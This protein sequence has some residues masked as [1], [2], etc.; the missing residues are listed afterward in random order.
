MP[1]NSG[2][3]RLALLATWLGACLSTPGKG[4]ACAW[5]HQPAAAGRGPGQRGAIDGAEPALSLLVLGDSSAA[6]VGIEQSGERA[7]R[8]A[9]GADRRKHRPRRALAG[10]RLQFGDLGP[11]PR[12]CRAQPR[13]RSVDA[14]RACHRHQRHQEFPLAA[15]L[16]EGVRRAALC[17]AR[18]MAGSPHRLVSRCIAF[19]DVPALPSAAWQA[20][21]NPRQRDQRIG[22]AGFASNAARVPA[23]AACRHRRRLPAFQAT[24][25]TPRKPAT[26]PGPSICC[27]S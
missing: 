1:N 8:A 7:R 18:Q 14:Y 11:D 13:R 22:R 27:R 23:T 6:S 16:Q 26:G 24:A 2:P 20:P 17:A 5:A 15:A 25:F 10:G 12:P 3:S 19:T 9:C 4:W 21:R